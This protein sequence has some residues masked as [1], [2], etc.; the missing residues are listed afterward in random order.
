[1]HSDG[2]PGNPT[3]PS[4]CIRDGL[5]YCVIGHCAEAI[6][7][8][9]EA[10]IHCRRI[11]VLSLFGRLVIEQAIKLNAELNHDKAEVAVVT[12]CVDADGVREWTLANPIFPAHTHVAIKLEDQEKSR[13]VLTA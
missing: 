10:F 13:P 9:E 4:L 7:A 3:T 8:R 2:L 12:L 5:L 11:E 1:M 6:A